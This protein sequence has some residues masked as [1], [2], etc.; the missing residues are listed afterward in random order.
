MMSKSYFTSLAP[1]RR[2]VHVD[3]DD[4]PDRD[5][6]HVVHGGFYKKGCG[7]GVSF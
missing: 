3:V 4:F 7:F 2:T 6:A 1:S 5:V